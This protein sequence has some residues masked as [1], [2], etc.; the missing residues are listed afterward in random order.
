[1]TETNNQI[2]VYEFK[3][4][5]S[6]NG[7]ECNR[8]GQ[9]R[10]IGSNVVKSLTPND[11]GYLHTRCNGC[12]YSVHRLI[13]ET[14][15]PNPDNLPHVD[16]INNNKSDNNYLNLRWVTVSENNFNRVLGNEVE[17]IPKE[18]TRIDEIRGHDFENVFYYNQCFYVDLEF[19]I[20]RYVGSISGKQKQ[21]KLYD[22]NNN[23]V[24]FS[25]KQ[26]LESWPQFRND[27]YPDEDNE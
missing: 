1:M 19:K 23:K 4:I 2:D 5:P 14:F 16:H 15:I 17:S 18:A 7:F 3:A 6:V 27:F 21:W 12:L 20:R 8:I 26:F 25:T 9:V 10:K 13:A 24:R 11:R 22:A